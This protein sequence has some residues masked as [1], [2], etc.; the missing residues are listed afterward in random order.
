MIEKAR[1]RNFWCAANGLNMI[2]FGIY[3]SLYNC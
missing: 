2:F 3:R 1:E